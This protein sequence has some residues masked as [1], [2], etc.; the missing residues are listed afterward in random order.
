MAKLQISIVSLVLFK[1]FTISNGCSDEHKKMLSEIEGEYNDYCALNKITH[2]KNDYFDDL[3]GYIDSAQA[4]NKSKESFLSI[5]LAFVNWSNGVGKA[6]VPEQ[7]IVHVLGEENFINV[8]NAFKPERFQ[9]KMSDEDYEKGFFQ[10]MN[11]AGKKT[12]KI[13]KKAIGKYNKFLLS[14]DNDVENML[15]NEA[16]VSERKNPNKQM[17]FVDDNNF[18]VHLGEQYVKIVDGVACIKHCV[19][20]D[21][22]GNLGEKRYSISNFISLN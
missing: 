8:T 7:K 13:F 16:I 14:I 22:V 18:P 6:D 2:S 15:K 3:F 4:S 11:L 21:Y 20:G 1:E 10:F 17:V 9:N 19:K 12:T 5:F